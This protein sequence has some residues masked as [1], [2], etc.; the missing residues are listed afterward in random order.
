MGHDV[1]AIEL[2]ITLLALAAAAGGHYALLL[3]QAG[4]TQYLAAPPPAADTPGC[5]TAQYSLLIGAA[6]T[7]L[8]EPY[9]RRIL[10]Q[11]GT[12]LIDWALR[13]PSMQRLIQEGNQLAPERRLIW[14]VRLLARFMEQYWARPLVSED[15][16]AHYIALEWCTTCARIVAATAPICMNSEALYAGLA[17]RLTGRPVQV[18]EVACAAQGAS[19][20]TFAFYKSA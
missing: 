16:Q 12:E 11:V 17:E 2:R 3:Q 6:Y 4:L 13:G 9:T 18:A 19:H 1:S 14:L 5:T 7:L 20:C 15:A 10:R 8:G